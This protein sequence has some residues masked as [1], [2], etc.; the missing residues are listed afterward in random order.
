MS[1]KLPRFEQSY[2]AAIFA[3]PEVTLAES[4]YRDG[5]FSFVKIFI[6]NFSEKF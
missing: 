4:H 6:S 5:N 3:S 1:R 2:M